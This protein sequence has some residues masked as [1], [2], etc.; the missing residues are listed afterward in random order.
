MA[1]PTNPDMEEPKEK[2][3]QGEGP[4]PETLGGLFMSGSIP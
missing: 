2:A 4:T 1:R 3:E